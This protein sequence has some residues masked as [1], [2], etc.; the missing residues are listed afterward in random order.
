MERNTNA[1]NDKLFKIEKSY[2]CGTNENESVTRSDSNVST[3]EIKRKMK[4][5]SEP[6]WQMSLLSRKQIKHYHIRDYNMSSKR[7]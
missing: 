5:L 7:K 2:T 6:Y 4:I 1:P 3:T